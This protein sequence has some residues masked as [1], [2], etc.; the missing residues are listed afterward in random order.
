MPLA[1]LVKKAGHLIKRAGHLALRCCGCGCPTQTCDDGCVM[2]RNGTAVFSGITVPTCQ[3]PAACDPL[4]G[5]LP[6]I[7]CPE[8][9]TCDGGSSDTSCP[10]TCG[11][12]YYFPSGGAE[13]G[14]NDVR[15][16]VNGIFD[17]AT[18]DACDLE[19]TTTCAPGD[20]GFFG[21]SS[22]QCCSSSAAGCLA[23]D[24]EDNYF[25][26]CIT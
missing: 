18:E 5:E 8:D 16:V 10:P 20:G 21:A 22:D 26:F 6:C 2:P 23:A 24:G 7:D 12:K 17:L 15:P 13:P 9:C 25:L 4:T 11:Y 19:S 14:A 1:H 3:D